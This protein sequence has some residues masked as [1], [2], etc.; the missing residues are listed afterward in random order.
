MALLTL[1]VNNI[2]T[3]LDKRFQEAGF[4]ARALR[5]AA[6]DIQAANGSQLSGN[7]VTEFGTVAGSWVVTPQAAS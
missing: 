4:L 5:T 2:T 6:N 7:I 3:P 1:T